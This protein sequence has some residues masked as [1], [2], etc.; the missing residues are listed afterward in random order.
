MKVII[1]IPEAK[2][3]VDEIYIRSLSG[4][5]PM[6]IAKHLKVKN[7]TFNSQ[8]LFYSINVFNRMLKPFRSRILISSPTFLSMKRFSKDIKLF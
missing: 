2:Q 1:Q 3:E 4:K 6:E 5:G 7:F 8:K